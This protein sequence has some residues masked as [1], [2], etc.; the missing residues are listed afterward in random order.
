[1]LVQWLPNSHPDVDN[2]IVRVRTTDLL[3]P[4]EEVITDYVIGP[5][6]NASG[7]AIVSNIAPGHTYYISIGAQALASGRIV[8]SQEQMI[9]T[10]QP[11]F[12]LSTDATN[13]QL[14]AGGNGVTI[15]LLVDM[16][17]DLPFAVALDLD[18]QRLPD[19]IY[20]TFD[21]GVIAAST[22]LAQSSISITASGTLLPGQ[23]VVPIM[24]RSAHESACLSAAYQSVTVLLPSLLTIVIRRV[25]REGAVSVCVELSTP[26]S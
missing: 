13:I 2:Y 21:A 15:P 7:S 9:I 12:L 10:P 18:Y 17:S 16:A 20:A 22:T 4:T 25:N 6:D 19:G 5:A 26:R 1:M 24:A 8:W 23:Y 3:T 11:E 14:V